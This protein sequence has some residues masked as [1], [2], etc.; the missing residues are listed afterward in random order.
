MN[1]FIKENTSYY[2]PI[3]YVLKVI[4]KNRDVKFLLVDEIS[5]AQIIYDYEDL[6][7]EDIDLKFYDNLEENTDQLKHEYFFTDSVMAVDK[8]EDLIAT[9]FTHK[10]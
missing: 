1:I 2:A 7:S 6:N 5:R 9:I 10:V 4:E 8:K 3:K